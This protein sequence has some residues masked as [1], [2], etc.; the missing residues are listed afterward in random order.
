[1]L[2]DG[3]RW[4]VGGFD[5][6]SPPDICVRADWPRRAGTIIRQAADYFWQPW[7]SDE[8]LLIKPGNVL[9]IDGS[10]AMTLDCPS[11]LSNSAT[12][13]L[14]G[15]HRFDGHVDRTIL[16]DQTL[17]MGSGLDC[18]IRTTEFSDQV[19]LI[20]RDGQWLAKPKHQDTLYPLP[21]GQRVCIGT[22]AMT[23][24]PA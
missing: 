15:S 23:L 24:E 18:H 8:S 6:Q 9:P 10:A 4:T 22:L 3:S 5:Q 14:R 20:N 21:E 19:V 16:L 11:P 1:M 7:Q 12:L 2:L 17:L 13:S